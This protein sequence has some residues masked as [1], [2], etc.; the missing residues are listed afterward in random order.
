MKNALASFIDDIFMKSLQWTLAR[1]EQFV[2]ETTK[3]GIVNNALSYMNDIKSKGHF[4][5]ACIQGLGGN[6][7]LD[8]RNQLA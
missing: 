4:V 5:F 3:V 6:F 2:V 1:Q 7:T 8:I